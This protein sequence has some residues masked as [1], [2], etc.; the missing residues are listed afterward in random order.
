MDYFL[1]NFIMMLNVII[2]SFFNPYLKF[3]DFSFFNPN[4]KSKPNPNPKP[5]DNNNN[6]NIDFYFIR[7][8]L[9]YQFF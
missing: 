1:K 6:N 2:F 8:L 9:S 3:L 4:P 7:I 5:N